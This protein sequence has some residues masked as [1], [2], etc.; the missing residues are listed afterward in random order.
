MPRPAFRS[1][2]PRVPPTR[3]R[4]NLFLARAGQGSRREADQWIREGRV[5]VNGHPPDGM[6]VPVTP[7]VDQ[8]TLDGAPV[9]LPE[10]ERYA[11]YHKP[12]R[13]LVSRRSQ[14]G[15][16]TIFELLGDRARGL[17]PVGRLDYDSEG[18]LLLT[19]DGALAEAL[20]H[21]RSALLRRYRVWVRPV[22]N[23]AIMRRLEEGAT[24]EG[25]AVRPRQV[26]LEGAERGCGVL[27]I[28][29]A[30]GKKRE[31]RVLAQGV[32]L[33]VERLLRIQFGP[34]HLA[35][36]RRGTL[37]MLSDREVDALRRAIAGPGTPARPRRV[38]PH[39]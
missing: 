14:G 28:D 1:R 21:P 25:V 19:S 5:R 18:L 23:P 33:H 39:G 27:L 2:P 7:G 11:A 15:K 9:A 26:T 10:L 16:A 36:Q 32:G 3:V 38:R 35:E 12:P 29:L 20:L 24:V 13:A 4:L 17:M 31:I 34:I 6:G 22:P 30:E 8:V 37:R